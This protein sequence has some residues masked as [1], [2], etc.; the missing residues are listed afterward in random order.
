MSGELMVEIGKRIKAAAGFRTLV[1]SCANGVLGYI[2]TAAALPEGG[3]ESKTFLYRKFPAPYD[4]TMEMLVIDRTLRLI[5]GFA[6]GD[7][8]TP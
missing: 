3:Y 5:R 8:G 7:E 4:K 2:P 1:G 6:K